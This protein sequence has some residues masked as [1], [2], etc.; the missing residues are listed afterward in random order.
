MHHER[1]HQ[2]RPL[3]QPDA[4]VPCGCAH[5]SSFDGV[6]GLHACV[7]A[8]LRSGEDL[9]THR[10]RAHHQWP[11]G[12]GNA[13]LHASGVRPGQVQA[14]SRA[15]VHGGRGTGPGAADPR[16]CRHGY[17]DQPGVRPHRN[18]W[19]G[20]SHLARGRG[21]ESWFH[22]Q[23]VLLVERARGA[24]RWHRLRAQRTWRSVGERR[25]HHARIL[26]SPRRNGECA[27]GRLALHRRRRHHG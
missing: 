15:L 6:R 8:R 1:L 22:R 16:L 3:H 13:E 17:R 21:V 2:T 4:D 18:V 27:Q 7:D 5:S 23:G 14:R 11:D 9:G 24:S 25:P 26:E 12:S 19:S 20:L 10:L